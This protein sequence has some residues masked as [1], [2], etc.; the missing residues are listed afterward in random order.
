MTNV[1]KS[2]IDMF[3]DGFE[4]VKENPILIV[5]GI[6]AGIAS[7]GS[8]AGEQAEIPELIIIAS[9]ISFLL[10]YLVHAAI[11]IKH[12]NRMQGKSVDVVDRIVSRFISLFGVG[13]GYFIVVFIGFVLFIL[14]GIYAALKLYPAFAICVIEDRRAI[15]S[16]KTSW[17]YT[18]GNLLKVLGIVA[19]SVLLTVG[20]VFVSGFAMIIGVL[21]GSMA[22][23][24]ITAVGVLAAIVIM[25]VIELTVEGAVADFVVQVGEETTTEPEV[26]ED[27]IEND[28]YSVE[29]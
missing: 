8:E 15:E 9:L 5:L 20:I 17:S 19:L 23:L 29:F 28:E 3:K 13:L 7:F 10:T 12:S 4:T 6:V 16:L 14:P 1:T 22:L 27:G 24:A 26:Q 2:V 18:G 21:S 25:T 11:H